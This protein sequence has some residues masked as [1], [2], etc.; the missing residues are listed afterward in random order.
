MRRA[1]SVSVFLCRDYRLLL[2]RHKRLGSW[3]P[4][5]GEMIL[6]ETPLEAAGREVR[7]ETGIEALFVHLGDDND[8]DGAPPGLLGYEEHHAGSKG[9]HLNFAFVA[10]LHDGAIIRPNHEFDEFRWV[11]LDELVGLRDGN[12]TPLNV[13]QL[14]FK[15]LRR[16]RAIGL[17]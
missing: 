9:V 10:F 1:F 16:V 11:N 8:I 13:A 12:H 15:A 6:G 17:R 7:E 4:V 14:G 3:L 2:I 5:G